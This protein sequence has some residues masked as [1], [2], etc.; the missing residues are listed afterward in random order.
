MPDLGGTDFIHVA[1]EDLESMRRD[2]GDLSRRMG[3]LE[4]KLLRLADWAGGSGLQ[5]E[6]HAQ[7]LR[8]SEIATPRNAGRSSLPTCTGLRKGEFSFND[9]SCTADCV[10]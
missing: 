7:P 1:R 8:L 4:S 9:E 3:D 2:F 6:E 10:S 5:A